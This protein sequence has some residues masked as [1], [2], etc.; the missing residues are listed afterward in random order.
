MILH[1]LT[2]SMAV[3][4]DIAELRAN[5]IAVACR[6]NGKTPNGRRIMEYRKEGIPETKAVAVQVV[7]GQMQLF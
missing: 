4:T 6:Q 7:R 2:G 5:G 3:H 1:T